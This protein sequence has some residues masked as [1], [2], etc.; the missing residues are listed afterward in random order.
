MSV[1]LR[2]GSALGH[3]W[4]GDLSAYDRQLKEIKAEAE[5]TKKTRARVVPWQLRIAAVRDSHPVEWVKMFA[6]TQGKHVVLVRKVT[7]NH[8]DLLKKVSTQ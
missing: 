6:L 4:E 3:H 1:L 8:A 5:R 2:A 7:A